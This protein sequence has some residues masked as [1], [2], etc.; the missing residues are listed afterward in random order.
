MKNVHY[1]VQKL[2]LL[3]FFSI[4]VSCQLKQDQALIAPKAKFLVSVKEAT[5]AA[6]LVA[7]KPEQNGLAQPGTSKARADASVERVISDITAHPD[8]INPSYYII[9]YA[10]GGFV[11]IAADKRVEPILAYSDNGHFLV[12]AK[13]PGGL[14]TW[15][16]KN[17]QNMQRLRKD[18]TLKIL[19]GIAK[20]WETLLP[21]N[22]I[23]FSGARAG[24]PCEDES[25]PTVIRGPLISVQWG[26]NC[27]YNDLCPVGPYGCNH[28]E[29][30]CVATAIAQI[31]YKHKV[32]ASY[33]WNGMPLNSGNSDVASLIRN[34]GSAVQMVYT[35]NRE[36]YPLNQDFSQGV[37]NLG[38]PSAVYSDYDLNTVISDI[39]NGWP[40]LLEG[41]PG[42][43]RSG[44]GHEWVC[45][46]TETHSA[47]ICETQSFITYSYLH[48]N[49]GWQ[50]ID[51]NSN[52][53][54]WF[55][56]GNWQVAPNGYDFQYSH[57]MIH[58]IHP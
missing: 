53:N 16:T 25:Y 40:V 13:L 28:T 58:G 33:N 23:M 32:P 49:W 24:S 55:L 15:I 8:A 35:T 3:C 18:T 10:G 50:E 51:S 14:A 7:G 4:I 56:Q 26:Q 6:K 21:N 12:T 45:D 46:G 37:R 52:P 44:D 30:G 11:I 27:T 39:G 2:S 43:N 42:P 9:N 22:Q 47:F 17:D 38:Y 20:L 5:A 1:Y 19:P 31:M 57:Y 34:V 48:M 54:G 36:S 41:W 29:T